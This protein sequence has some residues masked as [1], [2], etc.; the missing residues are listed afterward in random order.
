MQ[1]AK[2]LAVQIH[3]SILFLKLL[4][5]V[6]RCGGLE[7]I[8][9]THKAG[10]NPGL[11]A[12]PLQSIVAHYSLTHT[13]TPISNVATPVSLSMFLDWGGGGLEFPEVTPQ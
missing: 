13:R 12:N 9:D 4:Q 8:P 7:P 1:T 10:N 6:Q 11:G 2:M 3:P 5:T